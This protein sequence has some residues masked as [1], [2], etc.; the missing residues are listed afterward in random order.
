MGSVPRVREGQLDTQQPDHPGP[1]RPH[2]H[3]AVVLLACSMLAVGLGIVWALGVA[4]P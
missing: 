4:G 2:P 3:F 1:S